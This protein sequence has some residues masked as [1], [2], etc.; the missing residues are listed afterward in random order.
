[1][2]KRVRSNSQEFTFCH[3]PCARVDNAVQR[4]LTSIAKG[5]EASG[6]DGEIKGPDVDP[7]L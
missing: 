5:D 6:R 7:E 3:P 2:E 1:M 4:G